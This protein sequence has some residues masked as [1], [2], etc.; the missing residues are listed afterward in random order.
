MIE[1]VMDFFD[2]LWSR[3]MEFRWPV[4]VCFGLVAV[5]LQMLLMLVCALAYG[6]YYLVTHLLIAGSRV[7]GYIILTATFLPFVKE[8]WTSSETVDVL[9][10]LTTDTMILGCL[11]MLCLQISSRIYFPE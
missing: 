7:A 6:I 5:P 10:Y 4:I 1:S 2:G 8:A 11:G 3:I 9:A